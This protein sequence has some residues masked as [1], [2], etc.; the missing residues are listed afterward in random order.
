MKLETTV[1]LLSFLLN[2]IG[3]MKPRSFHLCAMVNTQG[4]FGSFTVFEDTTG[5]SNILDHYLPAC[6]MECAVMGATITFM[7]L[8][9][10]SP[11]VLFRNSGRCW[12]NL[13]ASNSKNHESPLVLR[14]KGKH[15]RERPGPRINNL[16]QS[17]CINIS[18]IQ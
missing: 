4:A 13:P 7:D 16:M 6:S 10:L 15:E 8:C 14:D 11:R 9:Y 17:R 12:V 18:G 2:H 3:T 1:D 5:L